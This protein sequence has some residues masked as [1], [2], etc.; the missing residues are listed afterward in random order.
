MS[1][2]AEP[3]TLGPLGGVSANGDRTQY[4]VTSSVKMRIRGYDTTLP[5]SGNVEGDLF[6]LEEV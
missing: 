3:L 5:A 1:D 4:L 2:T 6:F